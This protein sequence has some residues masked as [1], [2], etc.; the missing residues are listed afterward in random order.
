MEQQ[1][2]TTKNNKVPWTIFIWAIGV[3]LL[4]LT[5]A[6]GVI[7]T[8]SQQTTKNREDIVDIK[9]FMGSTQ[10]TLINIDKTLIR[11]EDQLK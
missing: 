5:T 8:N 7:A 6:F 2:G 9:V 10:Q 3:I 1:N 11:I 4:L